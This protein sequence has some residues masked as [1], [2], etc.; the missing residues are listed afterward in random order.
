ML[1]EYYNFDPMVVRFAAAG[2]LFLVMLGCRGGDE[3]PAQ[4]DLKV[5]TTSPAGG[6]SAVT[7][8]LAPSLGPPSTLI[9]L[10][11]QGDAELPVKAEPAVMD[12]SGYEFLPGFLI[13][14]AGQ[15]VQFRNSEDVLHNVR[16]AEAS[17]QKPIF[18][19]AT[20]A[21]GNYE[22]KFDAG[23]YNVTCD[24]HPTMRASILVTASPYTTT[25][26][27]D[28]SFSIPDVKPGR[29]NLAVYAG[30]APV[31]RPVEVKDGKTELGMVQ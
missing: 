25:T 15:T 10:E 12:Q 9:V 28:G 23:Y 20:V 3:A 27:A 24:I 7:G 30:A 29:Y 2:A 5:G 8:T 22:H 4:A 13:A 16:V 21:F 14:Q 19:V 31:V 11:A 18:N 1:S 6:N 17:T 26:A